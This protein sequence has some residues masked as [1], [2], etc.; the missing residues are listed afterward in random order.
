METWVEKYRPKRLKDV[1]GNSSAVN[2]L[3]KWVE[4]WRRGKPEKKAI[5][6][7]GPP[8]VGKTS[9]AYALAN[10]LGYDYIELNASDTRTYSI[11]N[12]IVGSA[13][14]TSTLSQEAMGRKLIILDEVEGIHGK[15]DFGGL[16]ALR[17][18]IK[19]TE[20][21]IIL[22]AND[23]WA[24][25]REFRDLVLMVGFKKIPTRTIV[26]VLK[27]ICMREGIKTSEKVLQIIATNANGDLRAAINDL[28]ALAQGKETLEMHDIELLN[29]RD[30]QIKIFDVLIRI[31]KTRYI[32]R[33]LEAV[34]EAEEDPERILRWLVE[35]VP[36]EYEKPED[37]AKAFDYLSRADIFFGRIRRRQDWGLMRYAIDF[38]SAGVAISKKE[39]YSKF[40]KYGYP[41]I[42]VIYAKTKKLR[43]QVDAIAEKIKEKLHCSKREAR[44]IYFPLLEI[45]LQSEEGPKLAH[46]LELTL[47]DIQFFVKDEKLSKEVYKKAKE[48]EKKNKKQLSIVEWSY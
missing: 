41:E 24:L 22:I 18:W 29:L 17:N 36:K 20:Q 26:K 5:L 10:E 42:F 39:K 21:P 14:T 9:V 19:K 43:E 47:E 27:E 15:Y 16:K 45:V 23:P 34:Q 1:V 6:L 44:E 48:I 11:I 32:G 35:N 12:R 13:S 31:L 38:M 37:L 46:E 40:V 8:G 7:Y 28:Q 25:P 4:E 3:V 30:S 2:T 33:A